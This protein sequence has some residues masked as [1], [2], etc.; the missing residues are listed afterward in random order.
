MLLFLFLERVLF[1][2]EFK[3]LRIGFRGVGN[4]F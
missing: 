3:E 4:V 2:I 1:W